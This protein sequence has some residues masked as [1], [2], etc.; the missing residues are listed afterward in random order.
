MWKLHRHYHFR[1]V[2]DDPRH[3]SFAITADGFGFHRKSLTQI[4]LEVLNASKN[5]RGKEHTVVPF[6]IIEGHVTHMVFFL[7]C[8]AAQMQK[9]SEGIDVF[10]PDVPNNMKAGVTS[11][12]FK[13]KSCIALA[14]AD[15]PAQASLMAMQAPTGTNGCRYGCQGESTRTAIEPNVCNLAELTKKV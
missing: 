12:S 5:N 1:C 8:L 11:G 13:M 14:S 4:S 2:P 15:M 6:A 3:L 10:W 9:L 7:E